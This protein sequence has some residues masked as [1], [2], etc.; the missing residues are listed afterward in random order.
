[1][2]SHT[3]RARP[4]LPD[5]VVTVAIAAGVAA[6]GAFL[7]VLLAGNGLNVM[8][9][10]RD[11]ALWGPRIDLPRWL[12][13]PVLDWGSGRL[14]GQLQFVLTSKVCKVDAGCFNAVGALE[15]AAA[16]AILVVLTRQLTRSL[17]MALAAAALWVTSAP[18]LGLALW[19]AARFDLLVFTLVLTAMSLW[20]WVAER[21]G[22]GRR[23]ST[24]VVV[25][26]LALLNLAFNAKE[27]AYILVGLLPIIAVV[28]GWARPGLVRRNLLLLAIPLLYAAWFIGHGLTHME[29]SYAARVSSQSLVGGALELARQGLGFGAQ[30]M[31]LPVGGDPIDGLRIVAAVLYAAL[32]L[33]LVTV[34]LV[35]GV[36]AWRASRARRDRRADPGTDAPR[37]SMVRIRRFLDRL[38]PGGGHVLVLLAVLAGTVPV[39]ARNDWPAAY[40]LLLPF[41]SVAVLGLL[42]IRRLARG[43]PWPRAVTGVALGLWAAAHVAILVSLLAPGSAHDQLVRDSARVRDIGAT[44]R[45]LLADQ[46]AGPIR[47]RTIGIPTTEFYL[48]RDPGRPR[49][50]TLQ[51]QVGPELFPYL[52]LDPGW[53]RPVTFLTAGSVGELATAP[54]DPAT[55]GDTTIAIDDQYR[56]LLLRVDDEV[57]VE[58][59]GAADLGGGG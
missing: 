28:R 21:P 3:P 12:A 59:P 56:L 45:W 25:A 32:A 51:W 27:I 13:F 40:Y 14:F 4:V 29:P 24:G 44:L 1:M 53:Q 37:G 55:A 41:W 39:I 34:A 49:L 19:Q 43:T 2:T 46:A 52:L 16:T 57:L 35:A 36:R 10:A 38:V 6:L 42:L 26:T 20:W 58:A 15:T 54:D 50:P 11:Y 48:I 23:G 7:V 9:E 18:L 47:W 31:Y 22:L 33:F 8:T 17:P 30:S 5:A